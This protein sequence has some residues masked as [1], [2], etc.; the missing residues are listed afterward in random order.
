MHYTIQINGERLFAECKETHQC[1]DNEEIVFKEGIKYLYHPRENLFRVWL[2][3]HKKIKSG[4]C[5]Y[6]GKNFYKYFKK[7][8]Y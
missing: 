4:Y 3:K 7:I 2:T 5:I 1:G 6:T 8:H